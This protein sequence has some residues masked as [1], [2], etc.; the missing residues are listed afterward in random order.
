MESVILIIDDNADIIEFLSDSLKPKYSVLWAYNG[1]GAFKILEQDTVHL[2]VS[3][4]MMP[5]MDGFELCSRVKSDINYCH[6]PV[7]LLTARKTLESRIEGLE[8]GADAYIEK[9]FSPRHLLAQIDN[10][11]TNRSKLK[12]FFA[13]SP[14]THIKSIAYSK[15]DEEFLEKITEIILSNLKNPDLDVEYLAKEMY[16]SRATL[17]RKISE[18]C[19]LSPNELIKINRLKKAAQLITEG[20]LKMYEISDIVGFTSQ[21]NFARCF[22][23]QFNMTASEFQAK[24]HKDGLA[25]LIS[26]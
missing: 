3:D 4:I 10:L 5:V 1:K 17:Y 20:K 22:F 21:H 9:P 18:I 11:L 24:S 25:P 26:A 2:I 7:I 23:K 14:L 15:T 19:N 8:N 12:D 16:K 13:S 6:I